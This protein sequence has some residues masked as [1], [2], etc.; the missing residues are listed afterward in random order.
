MNVP[1]CNS[2]AYK[3]DSAVLKEKV[4]AE[5][6]RLFDVKLKRDHFPGP[7]PV[8]IEIKNIPSLDSNYMVCEKTDGERGILLFINIDNKPMCFIINRNNELYFT[9]LSIKKEIFE[10][11]I[12]DGEIIKTKEDTWNF[13]I[14]DCMCYNGV[15]FL[16]E[17]HNLR[18]ACSI[19]FLLKR[20][21]PKETDC[22]TLKTKLFYSYGNKL[23]KTWEHIQ[24]TTENKIDG[25]IFTPV[26]HPITFG[27]DY[28]VLKWKEIH[29]IDF[30]VKKEKAINL[31]Y[32]KK[33]ELV[34]YKTLSKENEKLVKKFVDLD[35]LKKGVI[36]EFQYNMDSDTF[37]PYRIRTDKDKPN[38]EITVKNTMINIEEAITI[39][40]LC[41]KESEV[42]VEIEK[43]TV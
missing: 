5:C 28:K 4:Y 33:S 19:D 1:F 22:F 42:E 25:L 41:K 17:M 20:Y 40:D 15:S 14:F 27:R 7:Q 34:L 30:L 36:V 35:S 8:T 10:G 37:I 39:N 31:Y 32:Q 12:F 2:S 26:D 11:S 43:L 23:D 21:S 18:Y 9:D 29:T 38:G 13:L 3:I 16:N 6:E 24:K